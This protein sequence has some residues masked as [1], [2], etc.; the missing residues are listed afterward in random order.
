MKKCECCEETLLWKDEIV[1]I[2]SNFYHLHCVVTLPTKFA[3]YNNNNFERFL[4]VCDEDDIGFACEML[5]DEEYLK[6]E[7]E[8]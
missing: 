3:V 1:Q 5:E 6:E 7:E 8:C 2:E 4:G